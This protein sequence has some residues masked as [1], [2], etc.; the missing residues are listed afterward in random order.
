MKDFKQFDAITGVSD[1]HY[2]A[3]N[4]KGKELRKD[5]TKRIQREWKTLE[6]NLPTSIFV[7]VYEDRI[8]LLRAAIIGASGT[9]YYN[10]L[11]FFDIF[12]PSDYPAQPP[13]VYYH[14]FGM[15]LNP[16]LYSNGYVCLSLLNTWSG[17]KKEKWSTESTIFQVLLSLQALVLNRKPYFNEP[18]RG[19]L[20]NKS[21]WE[22]TSMAYNE[23][24]WEKN[25]KTMMFLLHRPP[26][27]FQALVNEHFREQ[28]LIIV[29]ACMAYV[30]GQVKVG[31][32]VVLGATS[33]SCGY[34]VSKKFRKSM[35]H[36]C[37]KLL[38]WFASKGASVENF[39]AEPLFITDATTVVKKKRQ[40]GNGIRKAIKKLM[41]VFGWRK[42]DK[43][44][45]DDENKL[46]T[47]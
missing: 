7:R 17:K 14:S 37:P 43:G 33:S 5:V 26:Q 3:S 41:Q 16:N 39:K 20:A 30:G 8:D 22:R 27:H 11:F 28:G 1:H 35:L 40:D 42:K 31:D 13:T 23:E 45:K 25:C 34:K 19:S 4:L 46:K 21:A 36:L 12:F 44:N 15:R 29:S 2:V 6:D 24:I 32:P 38:D 18:G 47:K 10:G 9:P